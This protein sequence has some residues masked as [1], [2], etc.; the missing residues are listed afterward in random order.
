TQVRR[1][2]NQVRRLSPATTACHGAYEEVRT[3]VDS[4]LVRLPL[5][6]RTVARNAGEALEN[7]AA[8]H[9]PRLTHP[10]RNSSGSIAGEC[11]YR[12]SSPP[13]RA[14][15]GNLV[16]LSALCG[17]FSAI[18]PINHLNRRGRREIRR[19]R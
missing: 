19:V 9:R 16:D 12:D 17:G 6:Q 8:Y 3:A 15:R 11:L 5:G 10:R 18:S 4:E 2:R 13:P 14:G 7:P 1:N